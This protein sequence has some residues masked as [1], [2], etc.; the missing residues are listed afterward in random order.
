MNV[1]D[2]LRSP[3]VVERLAAM[4]EAAEN[5][6]NDSA[7]LAALV[8]C[9]GDEKKVV[10]RRAAEVLVALS[11]RS[12]AVHQALQTT[13]RSAAPRQRWGAAFAFSLLG[14]PPPDVLPVLLES[15]GSDD[16]DVRWAAAGAL[17]QM[18]NRNDLSVALHTLL[19]TG[20]AAQRKMAAYCLRDLDTRSPA[21]EQALFA[22]LDDADAG[23]RLAAMSSL[24][25]LCANRAVVAQRV[26][27]LLADAAAG[28]R[29]AAAAALGSLG[30]RSEPVLSALRVAAASADPSLQRAARR[31][32]RLLGS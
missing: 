1:A 15:L 27:T 29:R 7:T 22:A 9:L 30:E 19:G 3:A 31:S 10:Q 5:G 4:A 21:A 25:R 20:N 17:V 6:R 16:G 11:G 14:V 28:V 32:L 23:V 24:I 8:E 13:L 18:S 2:R 12:P 26:M